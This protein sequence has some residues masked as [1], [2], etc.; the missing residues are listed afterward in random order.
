MT[1]SMKKPYAITIR[2]TIKN[3]TPSIAALITEMLI[4]VYADCHSC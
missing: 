4:V 3:A 1:L 2:L